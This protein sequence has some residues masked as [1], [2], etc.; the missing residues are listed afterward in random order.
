MLGN[1]LMM[2]HNT[3]SGGKDD[4]TELSGRKDLVAP[5]FNLVDWNVESWG[6]DSAFVNSS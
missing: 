3:I 4:M 6:N 5:V 1:S 2:I